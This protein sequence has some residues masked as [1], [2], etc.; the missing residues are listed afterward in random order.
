MKV[1]D[2]ISGSYYL[3]VTKDYSNNFKIKLLEYANSMC[4]N[5]KQEQWCSYFG[6]SAIFFSKFFTNFLEGR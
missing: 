2:K 5:Y 3:N 6:G 4:Y 1:Q